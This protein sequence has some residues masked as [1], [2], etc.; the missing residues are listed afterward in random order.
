MRVNSYYSVQITCSLI[1]PGLQTKC[2]TFFRL[3]LLALHSTDTSNTDYIYTVGVGICV[4]SFGL[5]FGWNQQVLLE[6]PG[7]FILSLIINQRLAY[8]Y[9]SFFLSLELSWAPDEWF[10]RIIITDEALLFVEALLFFSLMRQTILKLESGVLELAVVASAHIWSF[11]CALIRIMRRAKTQ[12]DQIYY[13][14]TVQI[15]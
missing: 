6:L 3:C 5:E 1:M 9:L 4:W 11:G 10:A 14:C 2:L 8:Y 7:G 13:L 12:H 15:C